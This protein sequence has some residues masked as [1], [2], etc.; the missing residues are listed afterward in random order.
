MYE[1]NK[2]LIIKSQSGDE[3]SLEKLITQNNGLI[4]SIVRRF[5]CRNV[6]VDDFDEANIQEVYDELTDIDEDQLND[7]SPSSISNFVLF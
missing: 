7:V 6:E 2:I 4:W 3:S 1:G 5:S